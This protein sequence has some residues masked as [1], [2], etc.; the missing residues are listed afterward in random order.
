MDNCKE[1]AME[2]CTPHK[3][4][5]AVKEVTLDLL[6]TKAKE[7]YNFQYKLFLDWCTKK[8]LKGMVKT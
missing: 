1:K 3:I 6:P 2:Y 8:K 4:G 5:N 7:K